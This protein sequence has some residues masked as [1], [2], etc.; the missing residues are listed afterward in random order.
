M[1]TY[2]FLSNVPDWKGAVNAR[3][4]PGPIDADYSTPSIEIAPDAHDSEI[5]SRIIALWPNHKV[6][7]ET[8]ETN[9]RK[10]FCVYRYD[11][12]ANP[13]SRP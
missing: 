11:E 3:Q 6:L 10:T 7:S 2:A 12:H 9:L 8:G 5:I 1:K 4:F 13:I